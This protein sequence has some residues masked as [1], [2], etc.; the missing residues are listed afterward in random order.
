MGDGDGRGALVVVCVGGGVRTQYKDGHGTVASVHGRCSRCSTTG[1][2]LLAAPYL[3]AG[4]QLGQVEAGDGQAG[5]WEGGGSGGRSGLG[6]ELRVLRQARRHGTRQLRLLA[7][8]FLR[9]RVGVRGG[10]MGGTL[11]AGG[12]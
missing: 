8:E 4:H 1:Q 11:R 2:A 9:L 6:Q 5:R 12:A 3:D 7:F 10:W